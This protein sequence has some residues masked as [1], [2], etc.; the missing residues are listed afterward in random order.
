MGNEAVSA[1]VLLLFLVLG[2]CRKKR[3]Q[4]VFKELLITTQKQKMVQETIQLSNCMVGQI[5]EGFS[6]R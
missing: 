4:F 2:G 5:G 6:G 3:I 1:Q